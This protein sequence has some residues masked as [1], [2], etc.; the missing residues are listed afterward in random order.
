MA[1]L[2]PQ[3]HGT[4]RFRIVSRIG[5]GAVGE[6]YKAMDETRGTFVALR[7][8]RNVSRNAGESLRQDFLALK[9][10]RNP[11]LVSLGDLDRVDGL[12]FYT[13][14]FVEGEPLLDY[15]RPRAGQKPHGAAGSG[16]LSELRL[17]S[18]LTQLVRAVHALHAAGRV[19]GNIEPEHVRVTPQGRL[20]LLEC[21]LSGSRDGRASEQRLLSALPFV[22]PERLEDAAASTASDWYSVGAVLFQALAGVS[23]F[24]SSGADLVDQK[25]KRPPELS[26]GRYPRELGELCLELLA[27]DPDARPDYDE[28]RARLG[29]VNESEPRPSQTLSLLGDAAPFLGRRRE[30]GLLAEAF[31]RTRHGAVSTLCL[32]GEAGLGK[33][34]LATQLARK[35]RNE[36]PHLVHLTGRCDPEGRRAFRGVSGAVDALSRY[37]ALQDAS[38]VATLLPPHTELLTRLFPTLLRIAIPD[39][40]EPAPR[41]PRALRRVALRALRTLLSD[42]SK[43]APMLVTL[44]NM[45][46]ADSDALSVLDE[47]LRS[48]EPPNMLL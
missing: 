30:L 31:E 10:V 45:Q 4:P 18:A 25:Q 39:T 20:V 2:E 38:S 40:R 9:A 22:A 34:T 8:L 17:R 13:M 33:R 7:T 44:D 11:G 27:I 6:L 3:F 14:E 1:I 43:R 36:Y 48:P 35:L 28:L 24:A 47:L 29:I 37:L 16:E 21:E 15:V 5:V 12:W 19:H 26:R 42:L 41:E 32:Y 46:W 23:P